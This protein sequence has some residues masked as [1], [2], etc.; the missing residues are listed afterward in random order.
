[1]MDGATIEGSA[2]PARPAR[3][4][5]LRAFWSPGRVL[6]CAVGLVVVLV[7]LLILRS[8]ALRSNELDAL[9]ALDLMGGEVFAAEEPAESMAELFHEGGELARRLPD[10]RL[11]AGGRLLFHHGYLFE[12]VPSES[13]GRALRAWPLAHGETGLG[14]FSSAAPGELLGHPNRAARWSGPGAAP[15]IPP[16]R[17][18]LGDLEPTGAPEAASDL[19]E[20]GGADGWRS[21]ELSDSRS[22]GM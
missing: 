22:S 20:P 12:L 10:S 21:V 17:L 16:I 8:L 9:W 1:M 2:S 7:T 6:L 18:E 3:A 5:A 4:A 14:A 15:P 11:L 13:G 19:S